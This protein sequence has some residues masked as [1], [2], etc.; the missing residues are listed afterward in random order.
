MPECRCSVLYQVKKR[1]QN[2]RASAMEPKVSGKSGRY[3]SVRKWDSLYGLSLLVCGREWVLVTPRSASRNA[4]GLDAMEDPLSAWMLSVSRS[5]R[6]LVMS[7]D[8]HWFGFVATSSGLTRAGWVAW[9]RRS[10]TSPWA[11]RMRYMLDTDA[12]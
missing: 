9:R 3:F 4:T 12:R 2:A 5:M 11:R 8:Q 1:W 7:H 10:L 6:C